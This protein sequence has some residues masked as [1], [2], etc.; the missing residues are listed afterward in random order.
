MADVTLQ[1]DLP[2]Y[3]RVTASSL[4]E[5]LDAVRSGREAVHLE[6]AGQALAARAL[7]RRPNRENE[8]RNNA[9][10]T[11]SVRSCET[12]DGVRHDLGG[13]N[14]RATVPVMM[15]RSGGQPLMSETVGHRLAARLEQRLARAVSMAALH[16]AESGLRASVLREIG[17]LAEHAD[18]ARSL[19]EAREDIR[20]I[21]ALAA[22]GVGS[23]RD[24]TILETM[25][26]AVE[27]DLDRLDGD[28]HDGAHNGAR[29]GNHAE[30]GQ[31]RRQADHADRDAP[32][33]DLAP[34]SMAAPAPQ[35]R[36]RRVVLMP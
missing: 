32:E 14:I 12:P 29:D 15:I 8:D 17:G 25:R 36:A 33:A 21:A 7:A 4:S 28:A 16:R 35:R 22:R 6:L 11:I 2:A 27:A 20:R 26:S 30:V 23:C 1:F 13:H 3:A 9:R 10:A 31:G 34:P 5:A 19:E 18:R 24:G